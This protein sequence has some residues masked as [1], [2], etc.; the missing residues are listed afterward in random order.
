MTNRPPPCPRRSL[1]IPA[2][3]VP[4]SLLNSAMART[5]ARALIGESP[6]PYR[7]PAPSSRLINLRGRSGGSGKLAEIFELEIDEEI[8]GRGGASRS[9]AAKRLE[10]VIHGIVVRRAAP[11]WLPFI[12][13]S[14]YWVPPPRKRSRGLVGILGAASSAMAEEE[15][16]SIRT[17]RGWPSPAHLQDLSPDPAE[18]NLIK[19]AIAL[20]EDEDS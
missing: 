9:A 16:L 13:G 10:D 14:S 20:S 12:P 7:A 3:P 17:A 2:P 1:Q 6:L 8:D 11:D 18:K 4:I 5:V 15:F 19:E